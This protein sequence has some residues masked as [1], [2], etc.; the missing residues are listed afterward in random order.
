MSTDL[1]VRTLK[2]IGCEGPRGLHFVHGVEPV[3]SV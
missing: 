3:G 1:L 2:A